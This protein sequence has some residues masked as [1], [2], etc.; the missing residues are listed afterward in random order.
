MWAT[1]RPWACCPREDS[2]PQPHPAALPHSL[3]CVCFACFLRAT[4]VPCSCGQLLPSS[5]PGSHPRNRAAWATRGGPAGSAPGLGPQG[6]Q[7]AQC[8][9]SGR[10]SPKMLSVYLLKFG[11]QTEMFSLRTIK[12]TSNGLFLE[13]EIPL[14]ES[15]RVYRAAAC[16]RRHCSWVSR[17]APGTLSLARKWGPTRRRGRSPWGS[18]HRS[19]GRPPAPRPHA[20]P[21]TPKHPSHN[22]KPGLR[23]RSGKGHL[24]ETV[25]YGPGPPR[26]SGGQRGGSQ[27]TRAAPP[28]EG[29][30][31]PDSPCGQRHHAQVWKAAVDRA[32]GRSWGVRGPLGKQRCRAWEDGAD[33]TPARE[34]WPCSPEVLVW[35]PCLERTETPEQKSSRHHGAGEGSGLVRVR[36]GRH[37]GTPVPSSCSSGRKSRTRHAALRGWTLACG[38]PWGRG[39]QRRSRR[40]PASPAFQ[41]ATRGWRLQRSK[42][43]TPQRW[44]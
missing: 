3:V 24:S 23:P 43:V 12:A 18:Q 44:S 10:P 8:L 15:D 5:K 30:V 35:W 17:A 9:A 25:L 19:R 29:G 1:C 11:P 36:P 22:S 34:A 37:S 42:W 6:I 16:G 28:P 21:H 13:T 33:R 2:P 20:S 4:W 7:R 38:R 27:S 39:W 31:G 14:P 40:G 41:G 26:S 32:G